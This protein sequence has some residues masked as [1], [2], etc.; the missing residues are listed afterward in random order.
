MEAAAS[1]V[2]SRDDMATSR[3][4]C[5]LITC[6]HSSLR[7]ATNRLTQESTMI[8]W[9]R[10]TTFLLGMLARSKPLETT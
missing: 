1:K 2:F 9:L 3:A 6:E 7:I 10:S 5:K 8:L 4:T